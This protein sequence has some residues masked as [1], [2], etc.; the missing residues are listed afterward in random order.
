[1]MR[2]ALVCF[3][4]CCCLWSFPLSCPAA[5]GAGSRKT[6]EV[7]ELWTGDV[8]TASFRMGMCFA[9][10]GKL[11]GVVLLRS[12]NGQVDVYHVYG[13]V[14]DNAF[15]ATHGSGHEISGRFL[16]RDRVAVRI[17]LANGMRLSTEADRVQDV[18]LTDDC[19]PLPETSKHQ[20]N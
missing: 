12:S 4:L 6:F 8:L 2:V 17:R 1:M 7:T 10:D 13:T 9:A 11:R 14:R 18:P 3:C 5:Q 20:H 16:S 15:S 19:A